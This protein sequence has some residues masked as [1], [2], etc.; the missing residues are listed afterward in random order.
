MN[1]LLRFKASRL[2]VVSTAI[3]FL[4][5]PCVSQ[6]SEQPKPDTTF[7]QQIAK[8]PGF[9]TDVGHLFERWQRELTFPQARG[10]STLLPL[11]PQ[12][13]TY[14]IAIPNYGNSAH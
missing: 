11:L 9:L 5:L 12:S 3:F 1:H 8:Y 4:V 6:N 10:Q 7:Q 14:F 13:T 2:F